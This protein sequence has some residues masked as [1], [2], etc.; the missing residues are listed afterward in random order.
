MTS[1]SRRHVCLRRRCVSLPVVLAVF[2]VGDAFAQ[3]TGTVASPVAR[4]GVSV[5]A[6]AGLAFD[7]DREGVANRFDYR[8]GVS[9][10]FRVS[11]MIFANDRGGAYRY[12]RVAAEAMYQFASG[13]QGW[14]SW[15]A[16]I[17][18]AGW[19]CDF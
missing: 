15:A 6:A 12:R 2:A 17:G 9:E 5:S 3:G 7:D 19:I 8:L 13:E 1:L 4:P 18:R 11:A 16:A 10:Q 14:S